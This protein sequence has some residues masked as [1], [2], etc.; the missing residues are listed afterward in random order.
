MIKI[1]GIS[2]CKLLYIGWINGG[3]LLCSAGNYVQ[4]PMM[5]HGGGEH[6]RI[7]MRVAGSLCCAAEI[8]T[9]L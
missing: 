5:D 9:A 6:E 7:Y 2:G 4:C 1:C 3:V 8:G